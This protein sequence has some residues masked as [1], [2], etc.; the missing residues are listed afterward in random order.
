MAKNRSS[1]KASVPVTGMTCA[2][3]ASHVEKALARLPGVSQASVNLASEKASLEYD[4][5]KLTM[6]KVVDAVSDSGYGVAVEKTTFGAGGMSCASCAA[7]IEK[8]LAKV[9]G[10]VSANVNLASEK[11][12][13]EYLRG[14]AGMIA[15]KRAVEDAGYHV[16]SG[17]EAGKKKVTFAVTGMTCASCV[18]HVEKAL[19]GVD[20]VSSANVN[21]ASEK[22]TVD[23]DPGKAGMAD[24]RKAVEEAGYGVGAELGTEGAPGPDAV[25]EAARR[26]TRTLLRKLFFAGAVGA[27]MLFIAISEFSGDWSWLPPFFSNRYLLWALATPVQFWAGWQFYRGA[28]GA[29]KH[30]TANMN[31]LI[32]VGTSAAYFYSVVAILFPAVFTAGGREASVYFDTAAI[33]IALILLGRFLEARAKGQTSEAIKKLI[34]MQARTARVVRSGEELDIPVEEVVVGDI[35]VVR[36][37][38]KVPVDGV[39][40]EGHSSIDESMVTGESMPVEKGAGNEVIG[41]TINKTGSFRFEAVKVGKDT[42]LA[43]IIKLV[44]EAQGS[45]A[46]IQRLADVIS[47]YF[48]PAVIG[49]GIITFVLWYIWGPAPALTFALLNFVAVL[50][51]AC[52]CALGLA[53]PTA[54]MVGTGKGAENGV[55][56]RSG[57]ALETAHKIKAIILDK[58][59][60]LTRGQ[61][62]VTDVVALPGFKEEQLLT[63]AASA[64]RGSEHPLGESI[65]NAARQKKLSLS[66]VTGFKAIPGQ[67]VEARI[68]GR[69]VLL[70]NQKLMRERKLSLNGL[71]EKVSYLSREGKTPILLGI[72]GQVAGIIAVADTLKPNSK[73]AVKELHRLGLEVVML[74]GDN[75]RTAQ[76]IAR[77]VGIDRVLAEVLPEHKAREVRKLQSEGKV[78]AMVG[79][80]INDAPALAQADVGIAIGTGTDVAMEAADITLMSGDLRGVVMAISLSKRTLRTIKQNLF[81]AFAYNVSL[82]PVA[83]GVLYF[84]FGQSGTPPALQFFLGNYGFLNPMLAAFAMAA[85][86]V[87]VVSNSL[88]LRS[89]RPPE[90]AAGGVNK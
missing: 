21:L 13:V 52:P 67:G 6:K 9:P 85:S 3:C 18:S 74:T 27:Y 83:A 61:P 56:I 31:T 11:A 19:K 87:T 82:I 65:V 34:G 64:E 57:G 14:E 5:D 8:A 16:L 10:V 84:V 30:K 15:F 58:T 89:F 1:K 25:T 70:G 81:W 78:V 71:E 24:F 55:L 54:I 29:L 63:M 33:I 48:V 36:P 37:G 12:T 40:K 72:D 22:A 42:V 47:A 20:G 28:W 49:I 43:Q 35:I 60:T 44:E 7:S 46:P 77:Q 51:I 41:A 76:A 2:S 62:A 79:D 68:D 88:R 53:T 86:S 23:Y 50:I 73:K 39:I 69:K 32:A 75:R 26:E 80:G 17:H 38:E 4:P 66:D 90:L 45:K 59:G